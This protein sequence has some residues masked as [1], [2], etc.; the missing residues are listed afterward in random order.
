MPAGCEDARIENLRQ[1]WRMRPVEDVHDS[2]K[3]RQRWHLLRGGSSIH[4][5]RWLLPEVKLQEWLFHHEEWKEDL[6]SWVVEDVSLIKNLF[7]AIMVSEI[8]KKKKV[9]WKIAGDEIEMATNTARTCAATVHCGHAEYCDASKTKS[10]WKGSGKLKNCYKSKFHYE[11]FRSEGLKN[12]EED[13]GGRR[14]EEENGGGRHREEENGGGRIL[15]FSVPQ[16]HGEQ[17][18]NVTACSDHN[19]CN[20]ANG[21]LCDMKLTDLNSGVKWKGV[22]IC[23]QCK[24]FSS[25]FFYYRPHF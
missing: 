3:S 25:L 11:P 13:R 20:L 21:E 4:V 7:T 18:K 9:D 15:I 16:C 19:D 22:G 10:T 14:R 2:R 23:C 24:S 6:L 5:P 8:F 1:G 17:P 12:G